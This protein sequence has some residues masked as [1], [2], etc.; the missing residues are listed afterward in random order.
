MAAIG[1]KTKS[2]TGVVLAV[3]AAVV[4]VSSSMAGWLSRSGGCPPRTGATNCSPGR[5]GVRPATLRRGAHR[6]DRRAGRCLARA[7]VPLLPR[8]A[9]LLRR[10]R[11]RR[12][13]AT[14][15]GHQHSAAPGLSLFEQLRA[16]V[17][18]YLRLRR[19]APPRRVGGLHGHGP[20]RPGAARHRRRRQRPAGQPHHRPHH[21]G[22]RRAARW[23]RSSA[24]CGSS[25]TAGWPSRSRC[26]A[27][28]SSTRRSTPG[29]V[30]DSC[31]HALLDAIARMPGIPALE[32]TSR[33]RCVLEHGARARIA[34]VGGSGT[35]ADGPMK[36]SDP[37]ARFSA[38]T[39]EWFTGTFAAPT[40]A[41]AEAWAAIA[42]GDNTLVIAPTGSGKTLAA[43]LWAIDRLASVGAKAADGRHPG[44]LRVAAQGARR[45]RR[46]QPQHPADRHRPGR[47]AARACPRP[48]IS[49]GVRSG[50]T[51]AQPA[52]RADRQ[53]ARHPHHHARVAVPDADLGGPG[54]ARRGRD[55]DRRRGARRRGHQARRPPGAVAGAA[56][57]AARTS[58][59]SASGCRPPSARRR[60]SP[61]SCPGQRPHHHRRADGG[62]DL[63]PVGPGAG[64]RHGQPREQ[65]HLARRRGTHRRPDRVAPAARSCSPTRAGSPSDSRRGSTRFTPNASGIETAD[66]AQPAGR[67]RLSRPDDGQRPGLRGASRCWPRP[68]TARSARNSARIVEDD[69]KSGRLKAVVATSSLELGIDMGAVDLV[70][71]V[72]APPSVA[73]GLQR[74]GRAGHQVGEIS[75][76]VLFPK[77]RTDL[78][79]CAVTV[80]R[81][82]SG[83]IETMRVPTNPLDVLAQH[84]VAACGARAARRRPLV[85]RGA[86][87]RPV[88]DV[89]A[90]RVR[91]DAGPAERQVPVH[92]VRRA[93]AA[94]GLRPRRGHAHRAARRAAAG[95]HLRWRDPRPRH[96][97]RVPGVV[98]RHRQA[99]AGRRTR[100]GDGLRVPARRR[101][102]ARRHQ[103]ADHRD[104]PRP[105]AR[106]CPRPASPPGCRS[107]AATASAGPPNWVPPSAR[108]PA[109]W[110]A[111]PRRVRR[112]LP[113]NGFQRL[114]RPTT[115]GSCS[116]T[117]GRPPAPCPPTPRS[118]SSASA[119]SSATGG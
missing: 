108:S 39:R 110:P 45:R 9:G 75:Q 118:S 10:R 3:P 86:A 68:T 100:R 94:T 72:E 47:R 65:H 66:G 89:A 43:F 92:R 115:C 42:D 34:V 59:P 60:R 8:Q 5:R 44:A 98:G 69:L 17:L 85:R 67:R 15:R 38:L 70:I 74:I 116:T 112:A 97:H 20:L 84:T 91:G 57:P 33:R 49:V 29:Y 107:G 105:R 19:G 26:A 61:G 18:A 27:S 12:G 4:H 64:A 53:A 14:V 50:D 7:D 52:P 106:R 36:P 114:R 40:A 77:H 41:Q 13:R 104:H 111:G 119:T 88:R 102:L 16:G 58:P 23:P 6:R 95:G 79:D 81:M 11:A 48:S 56:R 117:S 35:M 71:Q 90:Q 101:H 96:V 31:A 37:L 24:T 103:L 1:G 78:I 54:D 46:T 113:R 25:S 76:G 30:A 83:E 93:A 109:S 62:Q 22:R 87:Q 82:L 55:R 2:D 32:L 63:R 28:A 21:R 80:Q 73:S 51:P 99:L